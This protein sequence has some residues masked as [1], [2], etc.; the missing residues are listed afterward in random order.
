MNV[1]C[2]IEFNGILHSKIRLWLETTFLSKIKSLKIPLEFQNGGQNSKMAAILMI[3]EQIC[4]LNFPVFGSNFAL[5][6]KILLILV[7]KCS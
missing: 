7:S 2:L 4:A 3:F 1:P 6:H 5:K